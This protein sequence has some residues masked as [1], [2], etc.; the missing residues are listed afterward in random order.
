LFENPKDSA[1]RRGS[2]WNDVK[3]PALRPT[4]CFCRAVPALLSSFHAPRY[5]PT[6]Q[7]ASSDPASNPNSAKVNSGRPAP[8]APAGRL[9]RNC[10]SFLL[11]LPQNVGLTEPVS[12]RGVHRLSTSGCDRYHS[13]THALSTR[14]P[15]GQ[16]LCKICIWRMHS[17]N[18]THS[19][20]HAVRSSTQ[21][22]DCWLRGIS[23]TP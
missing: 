13:D 1:V 11:D 5:S 23:H 2:S 6:S 14:P 4:H 19:A 15:Q 7:V 18:D 20:A 3:R 8:L 21:G 12:A 22:K 9:L 10:P 16:A 17:A